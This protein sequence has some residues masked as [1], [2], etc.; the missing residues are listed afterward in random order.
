MGPVLE[1]AR[2]LLAEA[3][4]T[5]TQLR[6]ALAEHFPDL[7]AGALAYACRNLLAF[8]QVPPRGLWGRTAQVRSTTAEAWLGRPLVAEPSIDDV[9]LRYIA[10][11]GPVTPG[12]VAAWS[13][14]TGFRAVVDRL[15]PRLR[16]FRDERGRELVDLPDAP[17]PDPDTPAPPR[18]LPEYDNA[19]LSHADRGR[20]VAGDGAAALPWGGAPLNGAVLVDGTCSAC[21]RIDRPKGDD[22]ATLVVHHLDGLG[23]GD[24]EAVAAEGA[25]VLAFL[26]ADAA[27]HDVRLVPV[28]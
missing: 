6:A 26:A 15:R 21:W 8:V 22:R 3:P 27:D 5:G 17:R 28:P 20:F 11:F 25:R 18:F 1:V 12:D 7:H 19:L 9:T 16:T 23:P 14:L 13:R 4:L 2:P 10:A 24:A